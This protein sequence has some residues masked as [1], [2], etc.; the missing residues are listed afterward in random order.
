MIAHDPILL[1]HKLLLSLSEFRNSSSLEESERSCTLTGYAAIL[2]H[3]CFII[4]LRG[5]WF[6]YGFRSPQQ[7]S[8]IM[9][10]KKTY[11][12]TPWTGITHCCTSKIF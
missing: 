5:F 6:R 1:L 12:F 3:R 11:G 7:L 2:C 4:F 10:V 8:G 9:A